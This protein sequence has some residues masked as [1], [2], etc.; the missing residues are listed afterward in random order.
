M[1]KLKIWLLTQ[2]RNKS[3]LAKKCNVSPTAVKYWLELRHQPSAKH[4]QMI[5]DITGIKE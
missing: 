1:A 4:R 5:A 3:W 2:E